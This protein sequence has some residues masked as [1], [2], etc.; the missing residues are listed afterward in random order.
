MRSLSL[1][2]LPIVTTTLTAVAIY[3]VY[4]KQQNWISHLQI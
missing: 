2:Q 3:D 4:D 1:Y